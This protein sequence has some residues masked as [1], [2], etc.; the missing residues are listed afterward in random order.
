MREHGADRLVPVPDDGRVFR[1][2]RRVRFGDVSPGGRARF[3]ALARYLQDVSNDDTVDAGLDDDMAW[4]V[5]RTV[6]DVVRPARFR[7][8]IELATFCSGIGSRWAE[9]RISIRGEHGAVIDAATLWVHVELPS[10]RPIPVDEQFRRIYGP[11]AA[12][13]EVTARLRHAAEVPAG[14][15]RRPFPVR[16]VDFDALDHVNNAASWAAVEE[17]L[18][19]CRDLRPPYRAEL[20]YRGPIERG[21]S[22]DLVAERSPSGSLAIWVV[23]T[24]SA[25]LY[26]TAMV[27]PMELAD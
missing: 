20:E 4:V 2:T 23:D 18:A 26:L 5:R 16:F 15:E 9:R 24:S 10:G 6:F 13:R 27:S 12:G 25:E 11:T 17:E 1:A 21:A 7:E 8:V 22:L 19:R 3:D 14:A